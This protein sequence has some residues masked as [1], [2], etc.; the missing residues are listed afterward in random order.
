M[1][2]EIWYYSAW[3]FD[4]IMGLVIEANEMSVMSLILDTKHEDWDQVRCAGE[5]DS[6]HNKSREVWYDRLLSG[7]EE[8]QMSIRQK[9]WYEGLLRSKNS[10][11]HS[12]HTHLMI[13]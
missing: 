9:F 11:L 5:F 4:T 12:T 10:R 13:Q 2:K 1:K 6:V 3:E 8:F 7:V